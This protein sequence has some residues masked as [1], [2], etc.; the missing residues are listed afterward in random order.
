M[1]LRLHLPAVSTLRLENPQASL[2]TF[3]FVCLQE[4]LEE[5]L[6]PEHPWQRLS[7]IIQQDDRLCN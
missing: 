5:V 4:W 3:P 6:C 1:Q 2:L 7:C